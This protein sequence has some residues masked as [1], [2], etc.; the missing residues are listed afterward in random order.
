MDIWGAFSPSSIHGHAYFLTIVHDYSRHTWIF[1]MK[2]KSEA[3]PLIMQFINMVQIQFNTSIK[4][5][6]SYN[7]KEFLMLDNYKNKGIIHQRTCIETPQQNVVVERKH[8]H[9]LN[10]AQAIM[11]H[12]HLPKIFW[13]FIVNRAVFLINKLPSPFTHAKSPYE[14][15]YGTTPDYDNIVFDCLVFA[16]TIMQGPQR[17]DP[18]ASKCIFLGYKHGIKGFIVMN[19]STHEISIN[20]NVSFHEQVFP[21]VPPPNIK[22]ST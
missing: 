22:S 4:Q 9:I 7:G 3:R 10:V 19:L 8:I 11:F 17:L 12:S 16:S 15:L 6:R 5:I 20:R 21:F 1:L 18:C 14:L 2:S 13:N